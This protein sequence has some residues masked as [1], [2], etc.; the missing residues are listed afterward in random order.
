MQT[1][2][3]KK[4]FSLRLGLTHVGETSSSSPRAL[5]VFT[6]QMFGTLYCFITRLDSRLSQV[7]IF[8]FLAPLHMWEKGTR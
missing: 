7:A 8:I 3:L 4:V 1:L 2:H 5:S 6:E